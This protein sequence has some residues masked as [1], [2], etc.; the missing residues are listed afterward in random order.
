M[1]AGIRSSYVDI[2]GIRAAGVEP[3]VDDQAEV[4]RLALHIVVGARGIDVDDMVR[5]VFSEVSRM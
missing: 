4:R 3:A 1:P 5:A 2:R